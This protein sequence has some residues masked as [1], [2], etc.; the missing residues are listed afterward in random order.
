MKEIRLVQPVL[1]TYEQECQA[2]V[3]KTRIPFVITPRAPTIA[4]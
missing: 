4:E 2:Q 1:Q 3:C